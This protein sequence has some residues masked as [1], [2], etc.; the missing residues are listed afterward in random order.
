M[1]SVRPFGDQDGSALAELMI[2]M[3]EFYGAT[4]AQDLS[5][6]DD[7]NRQ[8]KAVDILVAV[9]GGDLLGFATSTVLYPVAGLIAFTY[10]PAN[11]CRY[12][13]QASGGGPIPDGRCRSSVQNK[14]HPAA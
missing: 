6:A 12:E 14:G 3:A 13:C 1:I 9:V 7:L 2:E 11:L 5:V 4:V 10:V 8:A